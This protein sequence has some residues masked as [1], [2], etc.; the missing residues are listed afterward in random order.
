MNTEDRVIRPFHGRAAYAV[1][2]VAQ[3]LDAQLL[4]SINRNSANS[5]LYSLPSPFIAERLVEGFS[6]DPRSFWLLNAL[7]ERR[8][9]LA[10]LGYE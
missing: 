3:D 10:R 4:V 1:I 7:A 6:A 2:T 9:V 5:I 8:N